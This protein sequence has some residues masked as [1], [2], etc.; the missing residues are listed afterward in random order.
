MKKVYLIKYRYYSK[1]KLSDWEFLCRAYGTRSEASLDAK[2]LE[3][4]YGWAHAKVVSI[5]AKE[6]E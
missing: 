2:E 6:G 5:D 3:E 1:N 4:K